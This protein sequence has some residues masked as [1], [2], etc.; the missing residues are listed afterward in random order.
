MVF[1][2]ILR[3]IIVSL[4]A[5]SKFTFALTYG[6][7]PYLS[8][9]DSQFIGQVNSPFSDSDLAAVADSVFF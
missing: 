7:T 1:K 3:L 4:L 6:P 2:F 5:V 8:K 9:S